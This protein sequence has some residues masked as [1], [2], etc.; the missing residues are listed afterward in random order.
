MRR[1]SAVR[2]AAMMFIICAFGGPS[3]RPLSSRRV[4][5]VVGVVLQLLDRVHRVLRLQR[6]IAGRRNAV[7]DGAVAGI[8]GRNI[9]LARRRHGRAP[10]PAFQ[11]EGSASRPV[12]VCLEKNAARSAMSWSV[13]FCTIGLHQHVHAVTRA[14]ARDLLASR[15]AAFWPASTGHSGLTLLPFR[16]WQAVQVAALV[17]PAAE[18]PTIDP[19]WL[20]RASPR[21]RQ[22]AETRPERPQQTKNSS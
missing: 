3:E 18:S 7:A 9:A 14:E 6:R 13:R 16:P 4:A 12:G 21:S 8:A 1:S 17:A 19:S 20:P 10:S 5:R 2:R 22:L 11:Y 15:T